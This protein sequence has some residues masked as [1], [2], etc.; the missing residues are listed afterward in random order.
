LFC[1]DNSREELAEGILLILH[2]P[3]LEHASS[4]IPHLVRLM[5]GPLAYKSSEKSLM[6]RANST[7]RNYS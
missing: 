1:S 2:A 4:G 5:A 3:Q 6:K 7:Y